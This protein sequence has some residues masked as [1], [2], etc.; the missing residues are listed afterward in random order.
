MISGTL[1]IGTRIRA[2]VASDVGS[3]LAR[4]EREGREAD[5]YFEEE[6]RV[7]RERKLRAPQRSAWRRLASLRP[8][9]LRLAL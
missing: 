6:Q 2:A 3:F 1:R 5:E 8:A 9:S 4:L 7:M